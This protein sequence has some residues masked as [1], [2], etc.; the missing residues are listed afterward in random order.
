MKGIG[1]EERFVQKAYEL[2]DEFYKETLDFRLKCI[3]NEEFY[4]SNHWHNVAKKEPDEPQPV[5]PVLFSTLENVLSDVMDSFPEAIILP[6]EE[7]DD[8]FAKELGDI[9]R[10]VLKRRKYRSV[11]RKKSRSLLKKGAAVQEVFWDDA[12]YNGL[13]DVN[14]REWDILNF[15]WDPKYENFQEGRAC[16]KFGFYEK[17]WFE[18]RYPEK[19]PLFRQ[20]GYTRQGYMG[21]T[22]PQDDMMIMEYWYKTYDGESGRQ[23]V[24]MAKLAGHVLLECSE[25]ELPNG[26]YAHGK[27]PFLL[28]AL[29]PMAGQPVGLSLIDIFK[30]LQLYADK[31]DQIILKNTL[32][33]GKLKLLINKNAD[34]DEE[35][36]CDWSREVVRAGR[37]DDAAVRW[38]QPA[39]LNPYVMAHFNSKIDSIKEESGQ[40]MF[41]RGEGGKG[42]TASVRNASPAL[43]AKRLTYDGLTDE[44]ME[45][46]VRDR[47]QAEY[48]DAYET[49]RFQNDR[50]QKWIQNSMAGV[51]PEYEQRLEA[52]REAF[53]V[54]KQS[55]RDGLLGRGTGR[56]SYAVDLMSRMDQEEAYQTILLQNEKKDRITQYNAEI[57]DLRMELMYADKKLTRAKKQNMEAQIEKLRQKRDQEWMENAK[58]EHQLEMSMLE[59]EQKKQKQEYD[60]A[61]RQAILALQQD[62]AAGG[63]SR[64]GSRSA[65][66]RNTAATDTQKT[67]ERIWAGLS[68]AQKLK[69][70]AKN[71][72]EINRTNGSLYEKYRK[73]VAAIEKALTKKSYN[74]DAGKTKGSLFGFLAR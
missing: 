17:E 20:D 71:G 73:E 72:A 56:S 13:G 58:Y 27:Y 59:Y 38:F 66:G 41:V 64:S 25:K 32:M 50:A 43:G 63:G 26:V 11:Y 8:V 68:D 35:A 74:A 14:I 19:T 48:L 42:V 31:L 15:L 10:Y 60:E 51:E 9:V 70:F 33:S 39:P 23:A 53:G 34:V 5:T 18:Q 46:R 3:E 12:L 62:K 69:Y 52:L 40:N 22:H 28:E 37:V 2:F 29:Y 36:L 21:E 30:N 45:G 47:Y 61:Y 67:I 44:Q 55:A 24:H 7:Q 54:Q 6:Q 49:Q 65:G 4:R 1:E 57:D 16:F